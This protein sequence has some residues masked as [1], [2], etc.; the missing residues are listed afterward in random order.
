MLHTTKLFEFLTIWAFVVVR[1]AVRK[2]FE[3]KFKAEHNCKSLLK[4]SHCACPSSPVQQRGDLLKDLSSQAVEIWP[5]RQ[6]V[7]DTP[8]S[9]LEASRRVF[10]N[11]MTKKTACSPSNES[12]YI[13]PPLQQFFLQCFWLS[14]PSEALSAGCQQRANKEQK[15]QGSSPTAHLTNSGTVDLNNEETS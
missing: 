1:N 14:V 11:T 13:E 7:P 6:A 12:S 15:N 4:E 5:Q 9:L 3:F 8:V 10:P 2:I